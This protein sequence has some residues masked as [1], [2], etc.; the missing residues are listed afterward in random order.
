MTSGGLVI[1]DVDTHW[2]TDG[3]A[4]SDH[5]LAPW[6]ELF[7]DSAD[8]LASAIAGDLLDALDHESRPTGRTL[9]PELVK[10]SEERYD[11]G[12]VR[13]QPVHHSDAAARVAW[14]DS[15]GIDHCL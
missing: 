7:P 6:R 13:L 3:L 11:D 12:V 1:I 15:V 5:P 10:L 2:E 14:M 4:P 9:L 8:F